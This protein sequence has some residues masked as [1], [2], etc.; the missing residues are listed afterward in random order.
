MAK[1]FQLNREEREELF[2]QDPSSRRD[3]GFQSFLVRL[4]EQYRP[5]TEEIGLTDEDVEDIAR[6]AFDYKQGGWEERLITI[7]GRHLG[8]RL[9]REK[10][11]PD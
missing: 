2:R 3:G 9:G 11:A 4:Q 10:N 5:G 8:P 6:H 7:F 1:F